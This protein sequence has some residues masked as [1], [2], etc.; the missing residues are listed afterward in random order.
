[1]HSSCFQKPEL[2]APQPAPSGIPLP[3][4]CRAPFRR[5]LQGLLRFC[6]RFLRNEP[7]LNIIPQLSKAHKENEVG[8]RHWRTE[9]GKRP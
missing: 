2:T 8:K 1:M 4:P 7:V 5:F 3:V 9:P 6:M